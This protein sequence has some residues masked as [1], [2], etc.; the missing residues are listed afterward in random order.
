MPPFKKEMTE[1]IDRNLNLY[2]WENEG[3]GDSLYMSEYKIYKKHW[4]VWEGLADRQQ[5]N[6]N[7][8]TK[9]HLFES[10]WSG[11]RRGGNIT[12][13]PWQ[14]VCEDILIL[15]VKTVKPR[16]PGSEGVPETQAHVHVSY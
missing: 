14:G 11:L 7:F 8:I 12:E 2:E 3:I 5:K 1:K 13:R 16:S 15:D 4:Q 9:V 10:V 6:T